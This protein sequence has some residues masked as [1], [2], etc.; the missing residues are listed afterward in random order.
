MT[1]KLTS[2][3]VVRETLTALGAEPSKA[4]GQNFLIDA[5]IVEILIRTADVQPSDVVLEIGPGLGVLTDA[6]TELAGAVV[7]VEKDRTFARHLRARFADQPRVTIIEGDF[8]E[9]DIPALIEMH[10]IN[11]VVANL[12]YNTGTR[13]LV[14]LMQAP[15]P[16]DL[17]VV[18]VQLEVGERLAAV[19]GDDGY[20]MLGVW[21]G[22]GY[23]VDL[24]KKVSP[25]CFLPP[26]GVWS[27]VT[28]LAARDPGQPV[29]PAP[30]LFYALTKE[31]FQ[32]RRKQLAGILDRAP[33][34]L[35]LPPEVT[36]ELLAA[37][38]ADSKARPEQLSV[39]QWLE[40]TA[41]VAALKEKN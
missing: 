32:H 35:R 13:M 33:D 10:K 15:R 39:T 8:L 29:R 25:S 18:T 5:N 38:G 30:A 37:L 17:M 2:P 14:E 3:R 27:V 40:L 26:P 7:A 36:R 11:K 24:R 9:Q 28:R 41:R 19:P 34:A 23:R 4:L 20:G 16:P 6:L 1:E 31:A 12:P 21:A 22:V